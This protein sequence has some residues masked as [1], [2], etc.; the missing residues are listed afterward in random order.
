ML[1]NIFRNVA[2][3]TAEERENLKIQIDMIS[4]NG[5]EFAEENDLDLNII[6]DYFLAGGKIESLN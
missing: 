5:S 2:L 1:E 4:Q 3:S 6:K